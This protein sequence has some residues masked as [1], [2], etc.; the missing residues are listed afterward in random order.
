[1]HQAE[2]G[3]G[4]YQH[5]VG[6][7]PLLLPHSMSKPPPI[8]VCCMT[9]VLQTAVASLQTAIKQNRKVVLCCYDKWPQLKLVWFIITT[10]LQSVATFTG[11][12]RMFATEI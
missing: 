3:S 4:L 7:S 5:V 12:C 11:D 10:A 9:T 1:M 6:V 2:I 8:T